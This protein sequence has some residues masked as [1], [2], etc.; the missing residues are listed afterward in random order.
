M[1][2]ETRALTSIRLIARDGK[3]L[4]SAPEAAET[5]GADH[6]IHQSSLRK[7]DAQGGVLR[8]LFQPVLLIELACCLVFAAAIVI[9]GCAYVIATRALWPI[10]LQNYELIW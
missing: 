3:L 4:S 9:V 5:E 6:A 7:Q 8:G 2:R 10:L 1:S